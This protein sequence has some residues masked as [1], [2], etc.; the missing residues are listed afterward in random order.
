VRRFLVAAAVVAALAGAVSAAE[1][2]L[3]PAPARFVTDNAGL[4]TPAAA[5]ALNARLAAYERGTGHQVLVYVD[6]TT[7]GAPIEDWAARA[8]SKWRLG[9]AGVDDGVAL[10]VFTGDRRMRIEVGYGLEDRVPDAVAKRI[11]EERI[12]PRLRAGDGDGAVRAGADALMA[13]IGGS[14]AGAAVPG[15]QPQ[16]LPAWASIVGLLVLFLVVGFGATHPSMAAW[17]LFTIASG[18]GRVGWGGGG[19]FSGWGGGGGGFSGGG[20]R[21]GGGGASGSW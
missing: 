5:A 14:P 7:G 19:G 3:P 17:L 1:P 16:R 8:F 13:A 11:I 4:L 18:R 6:R 12:A 15:E 20:G 21:S 9:R 10:F 2:P